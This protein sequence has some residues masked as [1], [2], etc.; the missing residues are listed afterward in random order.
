MKQLSREKRLQ[1]MLKPEHIVFVGGSAVVPSIE[2][3][4]RLGFRG[5]VNV[6][7]PTRE[8]LCEIPCYRSAVDIEGRIDLAFVAVPLAA[9]VEA[10][11]DLAAAGV[12]A[13]IVNTAG[14]SETGSAG[15][16]LEARLQEAAGEMPF[17]GPNC[18]G[19]VNLLD[20][21]GAMI[22]NLGVM[23][24]DRGVAVISNGG[25]FLADISC[26]DR[27]IPLSY[28]IGT[29]NQANLS[30]PEMMTAVLGDERVSAVLLYLESFPDCAKLASA[31]LAALH[32]EIPV[33][34]LKCGNSRSGSRAAQSHT[35]S[36]AGDR[37][38][39]SA[40]FR[41]LRIVEVDSASEALETL[42]MFSYAR[43]V[44]GSKIAFATSSGTY[45]VTGA[46]ALERRGFELPTLSDDARARVQAHIAP[47][48][49]A[50][51]PLDIATGQF[52]PDADQEKI[53]GA[54]L[55][56]AYDLALQ[57][58]SF[59]AANTWEDESW[60]RS[61]RVFAR[62][63][64]ARDIQPVFLSPTH[65]GLPRAAREM[66]IA[67]GSVPLQGYHEG[68]L[69]L[70]RAR[71]WWASRSKLDPRRIGAPAPLPVVRASPVPLAELE[72]K[73]RL[74]ARD[75]SV[76]AGCRWC[77]QA[78]LPDGLRYPLVLK[79]LDPP[80]WHK[81]ECGGV[82]IGIAN[83]EELLEA[84]TTMLEDLSRCGIEA[85]AFL[86]EEQVA[87]VT[88]ELML[89][90]RRVPEVGLALTLAMGGT[91]VE[92][93]DD[94]VTLIMPVDGDEILEA[95][96]R[97]KLYPLLTGWRGT[98]KSDIRQIVATIL[99]ICRFAEDNST[100]LVEL[101]INPLA[102]RGN[103]APIVLDAVLTLEAE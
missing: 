94:C 66:L 28:L 2:Y 97:L 98:Q 79:L 11:G 71:D 41:K 56:D 63:A 39:A 81:S 93:L 9:A 68:C 42:K 60:Y 54:L 8:T 62:T 78:P 37:A 74:R 102:I 25:A 91:L 67:E 101:E 83:A 59:P 75:V 1:R 6:V 52:I 38:I 99:T 103:Q 26:S 87:G 47:F 43:A 85:R 23:Q 12:G 55:A 15:A 61:A 96:T 76:P 90:I 48:L 49:K 27:S 18:P 50:D 10:V 69:A 95:L 100:I 24:F 21:A 53:F 30:I 35:A 64:H 44:T 32:N 16:S 88:A 73:H 72:A 31:A 33:V 84:R 17:M 45:A 3:N 89:G 4:R 14:F 20:R 92:L 22:D 34:A 7:N 29:G 70:A 5:E 65:E 40:L 77:L 19:M 86:V 82:R 46:D 13:A 80:L 57:C 58:M 51:N 36:M